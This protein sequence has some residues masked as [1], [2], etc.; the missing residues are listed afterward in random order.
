MYAP[1]PGS[2]PYWGLW[3]VTL[4]VVISLAAVVAACFAGAAT[5]QSTVGELLEQGGKQ[6][7]KA[8]FI[9]LMP[10]RVEQKWANR[11]GEESLL[12]SADGKISGSGYHYGSRSDSPVTGSWS[13]ADDGQICT[14][15]TFTAWNN[16]T[17]LCWYVFVR[18]GTYFG[19]AK[20]EKDSKLVPVT[21]FKP[22]G[23]AK[24]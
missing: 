10:V 8:D 21:S 9:G 11:Q 5:A 16:S 20:A 13:L 17:N 14:P 1:S 3:E 19:S 4:K 6:L 18:N 15:K 22:A 23:D 7:A 2:V 24:N 12:L